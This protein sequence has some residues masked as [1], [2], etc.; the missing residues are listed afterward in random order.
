MSVANEICAAH[1]ACRTTLEFL[2]G[3]LQ[4]TRA[5]IADSEPP[6]VCGD[7]GSNSEVKATAIAESL[8][9][10]VI[11]HKRALEALSGVEAQFVKAL[12]SLP[13]ING[14]SGRSY[15]EVCLES[16]GRLL[17][18][19]CM[20]DEEHFGFLLEA[21]A[22]E[23]LDSEAVFGGLVHVDDRISEF[24]KAASRAIRDHPTEWW[25]AVRSRRPDIKQLLDGIDKE[26]EHCHAGLSTGPA[27]VRVTGE[28]GIAGTEREPAWKRLQ[29]Y[30]SGKGDDI[31]ALDG[32]T[33]RIKGLKVR[34]FL[35]C[36]QAA[37]GKT[38]SGKH[39][40]SIRIPRPDRVYKKLPDELGKIIDPPGRGHV[41]H[42]ML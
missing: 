34:P 35:A 4:S 14:I 32:Q 2:H 21:I 38:V 13:V 15:H 11:R 23:A 20:Y 29:L 27:D 7:V 39:F 5:E 40:A 25:N 30:T 36:L 24:G 31:A 8:V 41:G 17:E 37:E 6:D 33:Y 16:I 26:F 18:W 19:A 28:H 9:E 12:T 3:W 1:E 10:L 42:R 22:D